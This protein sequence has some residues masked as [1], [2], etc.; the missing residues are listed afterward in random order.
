MV[1]YVGNREE[2][3]FL[4]RDNVKGRRRGETIVFSKHVQ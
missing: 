4:G 2:K 1:I 3:S